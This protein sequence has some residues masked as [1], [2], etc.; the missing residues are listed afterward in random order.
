MNVFPLKPQSLS[1]KGEFALATLRDHDNFQVK[2]RMKE[3]LIRTFSLAPIT[4]SIVAVIY[5][6]Q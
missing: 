3:T 5:H 4:Q 1:V 6:F 2:I